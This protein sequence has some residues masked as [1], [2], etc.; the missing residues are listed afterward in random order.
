[1]TDLREKRPDFLNKLL[2][3]RKKISA[4]NTDVYAQ[5]ISLTEA[6]VAD[7]KAGGVISVKLSD[8]NKSHESGKCVEN[9]SLRIIFDYYAKFQPPAGWGGLTF[10][11]RQVADETMSIF[12][13]TVFCRNFRII[14][15]LLTKQ[16]LTFLWKAMNIQRV[17]NGLS[18]K[19]DIDYEDFKLFIVRIAV[20]AYNKPGML[21]MIQA[22]G[23]IIPDHALMVESIANFLQLHTSDS[24]RS[25]I[26]K[27]GREAG[28]N[29][30]KGKLAKAQIMEDM[31]A[32]RMGQVMA[33][34]NEPFTGGA[35]H[36]GHASEE[37]SRRGSPRD[38][39]D[40]GHLRSPT[41]PF[42]P[43]ASQEM[44]QTQ[45]LKV[46]SAIETRKMTA[47]NGDEILNSVAALLAQISRENVYSENQFKDYSD[48]KLEHLKVQRK[49]TVSRLERPVFTLVQ[50]A[51][52][53]GVV[54]SENQEKALLTFDSNLSRYLDRFSK[55]LYGE[56]VT[57]ADHYLDRSAGP[58]LDFG[59]VKAGTKLKINV[60]VKNISDQH[61]EMDIAV[62]AFQSDEV[63]V[64]TIPKAF[65]PGLVCNATVSVTVP[66]SSQ[67][68]IG[69]IDVLAV[70]T[71][72]KAS[73]VVSCPVF[74]RVL[75]DISVR[76]KSG[77]PLSKDNTK[78]SASLGR[79]FTASTDEGTLDMKTL[80]ALSS[81]FREVQPPARVSFEDASPKEDARESWR[82]PLTAGLSK[83]DWKRSAQRE[84]L[85]KWDTTKAVMHVV[86]AFNS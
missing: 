57:K 22:I 20:F 48:N 9:S 16:E 49:M 79:P 64:T 25:V 11:E 50:L 37:Q 40:E 60:Q 75:Q 73:V 21:T 77:M 80:P 62:R 10:T 36:S 28:A 2:D 53:P 82:R 34:G 69:M 70:P 83:T 56:G 12:E 65:A 39:E 19:K 30:L 61:I 8:A 1:M 51:N 26:D 23:G 68:V 52:V 5:F 32:R 47:V 43:T 66:Q 86:D 13:L 35:V 59:K 67:S 38:G 76:P 84:A 41:K 54:V 33:T 14:P 58:F 15:N 44:F 72:N 81:K 17:K 55:V 6:A 42:Q 78:R 74:Y 63:V 27:W 85:G 7:A 3:V 46:A 71:R 29:T 24:V 45:T 31:H 18:V 4:D